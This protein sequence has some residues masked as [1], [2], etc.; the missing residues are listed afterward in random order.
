[1]KKLLRFLGTLLLVL[2]VVV[3][4][5]FIIHNEPLPKGEAGEKAEALTKKMAKAMNY[6]AF[7]SAEVLEWGFRD[8]NY[9]KW[10][11]KEGIVYIQLENEAIQLNLNDYSKSIPNNTKL[12]E[13]AVKNFNNDSFWLVAPYKIFDEGVERKYVNY[14]NQDA[15][16]VT[17]TSGGTTPGDSYLWILD[18]TYIPKSYKMWVDIIPIGGIGA[19]W[20]EWENTESGVKLPT[21]HKLSLF[22]LE[23]GMGDVKASNPKADELAN[24]ILQAIKHEAYKNTRY[25]EWSFAEK[26]FFKWDKKNHVIDV[27]WDDNHVVLHPNNMEKSTAYINEKEVKNEALTKR[28]LD[29]FN[30]D[31][32][33]LVAP[34]KLFEPGIIRSITKIDGKEALQVKYTQGGS[35][36][37]DSYIWLLNDSNY[38][39]ESY[40]MYVPSMKMNGTSATWEDWIKTESGTLLPKSHKF[41]NGR[42]LSMGDVKGYN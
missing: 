20:S 25:L 32:F 11:K 41:S 31:S 10:N 2:L 29:I 9:Y 7:E 15:L 4:I 26:R 18:T 22:G 40:K 1:M 34:H 38:I 6:E 37:G 16:L 17:Y 27:K 3:G 19:T 42:T 30:N 28:A 5:L 33:W 35:T 21:N 39:P 23:L 13:K 12:I 36:P 14:N 24:N 8:K